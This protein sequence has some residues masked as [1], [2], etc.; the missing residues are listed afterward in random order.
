MK[1]RSG[2]DIVEAKEFKASLKSGGP[3]FLHRVFLPSELT[4]PEPTHLAGVFAAKE[5]VIKALALP[6]GSWLAIEI[7][8]EQSG[9]PFAVVDSPVTLK[10]SDLS[11]SHTKTV[12]VAVFVAIA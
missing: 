10:D 11:I 4:R 12:A 9:R 6:I 5:A 8:Y 1:I 3:T 7:R 2:I